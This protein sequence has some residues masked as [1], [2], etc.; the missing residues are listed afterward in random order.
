MKALLPFLALYRRH[1]FRISLGILLAIF[2][3][4]ASIG[5]LM[6][7]GWFLAASALAGLFLITTFNYMLPAA[8][9]RGAAIIRTA[10]RYAERVISHDT[11]FRVLTHLRIFSFRKLFPLTPGAIAE[12]RQAELLNRLVADINT[13]D[14]LYLRLISPIV[15]ALVVIAVVTVGLSFIDLSLAMTLGGIMLA[16]VCSVPWVFY[17][18]GKP[19]GGQ[20]TALRGDYRTQL[21]S[22][23]QGQAEL[24]VF[25]ALPRFRQQLDDIETRW[26]DQQKR[27]AALSGYSQ[28]LMILAS[29]LTLTLILWLASSGVGSNATPGALIALFVFASLASFEALAP[30]AGA[31]QHLGHVI[32]SANRVKELIDRQPEVTFSTH[33]PSAPAAI[34]LSI[35]DLSFSYPNQHQMVLQNISIDIQAGQH[36]AILGKTGCGKSTLMQLLTRAWDPQHGNILLNG[37]SLADYD[38]STLRSLMSVVNQRVHIFSDTLRYNL[39]IADANATD[40]QMEK[41]LAQVGLEK[42]LDEQGLNAWLGEGG[43]QLSGGERRRIGLVRALLHRAPLILLD[44]PTEGLDAETERQILALLRSHAA[45]KTL[46]MVTH[47]LSGL[48][49]MDTICIIDAGRLIES[50]DHASL[51]VA[52][53]RY[54]DF[55]QQ[56]R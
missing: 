18:A 54:Y 19:I 49:N 36:I 20:L 48:E 15:S 7:S 13:L 56:A 27:Q 47:R 6:L 16:L 52:K 9:V 41:V 21:T 25:G 45:D 17:L 46:I 42:L 8:G 35:N 14:H 24:S 44:E 3:L 5:L 51:L 26:I 2:T 32:A 11:T 1:W 53:G 55:H 30:I 22:W 39:L 12:Y 28:S 10:S 33:G 31:F 23:L 38:E 40:S 4:L 50:G 43:R 34:N 29:G 37:H